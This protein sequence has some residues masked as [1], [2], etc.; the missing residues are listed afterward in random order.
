MSK[1]GK[2]PECH[3]TGKS[4]QWMMSEFPVPIPCPECGGS[5]L[6][7]NTKEGEGEA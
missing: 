7:P 4:I 3:G 1:E 2:C 5:G 6:S